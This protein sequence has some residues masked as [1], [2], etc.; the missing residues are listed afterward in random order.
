MI[1]LKPINIDNIN[2]FIGTSYDK[3][4]F[5]EKQNM[6]LESINKSHNN[7][8][9]EFLVVYKNDIVIGFMNLFAH[10]KHIISCGPTIKDGFQ[11]KGF[12]FEAET[13][14]LKYS[15]EKGF[16]IAVSGVDENNVASIK[17][18]EKLGFELD[19][20]YSNKQGRTIRLYIK[21]I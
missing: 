2:D 13:L 16:T 20:K 9:F 21:S 18:H 7:Q 11:G 8:Y 12:G 1:H 19:R 6:I 10:S 3:M 5:E 17:L 15:R 14:A 4:T